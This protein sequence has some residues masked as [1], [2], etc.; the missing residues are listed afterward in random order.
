MLLYINPFIINVFNIH[1]LPLLIIFNKVIINFQII[2][3]KREVH[4]VM[5]LFMLFFKDTLY[6]VLSFKWINNK[7][8]I[9]I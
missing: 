9:Q 4:K 7:I 2:S 8:L 5:Y 1:I 3:I 6:F